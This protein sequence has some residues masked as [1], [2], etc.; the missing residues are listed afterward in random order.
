MIRTG[1]VVSGGGGRVEVCFD[2]PEACA[3]CRA[4]AGQKHHTLTEIRGDAPV[5][6]FVDVEMPDGQVVKATAL[7]YVLP[8]G[9]LLAGV[10]LGTL[11]SETEWVWAA[12]GFACMGV[13]WLALRFIDRRMRKKQVWEP[14]IVAVH[15]KGDTQNGTDTDGTEL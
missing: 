7:A 11:V 5:G 4:C 15:E 8:M 1:K 3:R 10:W 6:A 14:R 9:A 2:R 12:C 13:A